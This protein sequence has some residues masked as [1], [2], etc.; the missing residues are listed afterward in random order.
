MKKTFMVFCTFILSFSLFIPLAK[1]A[2]FSDVTTNNRFYNEILFLADEGIISGF[3]DGKFKPGQEVT[4]AAAAIMIGKALHLDGANRKTPFKDVNPANTAS[5]Y[6]ASAT[7]K[8]IISG[9]PDGTFR[10]NEFVTRGQMAILLA[11]AFELTKEEEIPF[12]DVNAKMAA[13]ASIKKLIAAGIASGYEDS[14]YRPNLVLKRDQFAAFMARAL[15]PF[16]IPGNEVPDFSVSFLNVGQGD[17]TLIQFPNKKTMLIDAGASESAI[18]R[19]LAALHIDQINIF[20]ATHPG[21]DH[22]G[23]ADY[24]INNMKVE[25]ILDSGLPGT[26]AEYKQYI[27]SAETKKIIRETMKTG[28]HLSPDK[29]A[30]VAVLHADSHAKNADDGSALIRIAYGDTSY[31]LASEAGTSVE[32]QLLSNPSLQADILKTA[33]NGTKEATSEA[34]IKAVN[35]LIAILSTDSEHSYSTEDVKKR[36]E[37]HEVEV[38]STFEGTIVTVNSPKSFYIFQEDF[39]KLTDILPSRMSAANSN[40]WRH[41]DK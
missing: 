16:F 2:Q 41:F 26:D 40:L 25:K 9:F 3:A 23:G 5:G 6:I 34:F 14:T 30:D 11:K 8:K 39:S 29:R 15:N 1:A 20:V 24:V 38:F 4:R 7:E 28:Q 22:I 13:Y 33:K 18:K 12:S 36:L 19:E 21:V 27:K 32:K 35:P 17:A 10:P 37:M 31:L